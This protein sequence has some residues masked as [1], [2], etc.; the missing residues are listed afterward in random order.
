MYSGLVVS[1]AVKPLLD[2]VEEKEQRGEEEK[3]MDSPNC[4]IT[5]T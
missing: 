1:I 2:S 3:L 4:Y 5:L